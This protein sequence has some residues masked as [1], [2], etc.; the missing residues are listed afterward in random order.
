[1]RQ[2]LTRSRAVAGVFVALMTVAGAIGEWRLSLALLPVAVLSIV[3]L[4]GVRRSPRL[5]L[6][7]L[8]LRFGSA[9]G[10]RTVARRLAIVVDPPSLDERYAWDS[11]TDKGIPRVVPARIADKHKLW[12]HWAFNI[13]ILRSGL[14]ISA[15]RSG[16]VVTVRFGEGDF[17][18]YNNDGKRW[19]RQH[20]RSGE[21]YDQR[22]SLQ[23]AFV[24]GLRH[25][26]SRRD[27]WTTTVGRGFPLRWASAGCLPLVEVDGKRWV[28][29]FFRDLRP[30]GWNVANGA[31]ESVHEQADLTRVLRREFREELTVLSENPLGGAGAHPV[32]VHLR[33]LVWAGEPRSKRFE[34]PGLKL[35][36]NHDHLTILD[37]EDVQSR[38]AI[39]VVPQDTPWRIRVISA[40]GASTWLDNTIPSIDAN[41]HG[42]EAIQVVSFR[43]D[44]DNVL[45]DGEDLEKIAALVR[46]PVALFSLDAL[47]AVYRQTGGLGT[48]LPT[49]SKALPSL[50]ASFFRVDDT[51]AKLAQVRR[52]A[53][54]GVDGETHAVERQHLAPCIERHE[55]LSHGRLEP[56]LQL[57]RLGPVAWSTLEAY[58]ALELGSLGADRDVVEPHSSS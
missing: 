42:V 44:E 37:N 31:S 25:A 8:R 24:A 4:V 26:A 54:A 9:T 56:R 6:L 12:P 51:E 19:L 5:W 3:L 7:W 2:S 22:G 13:R 43:V 58:F 38:D 35:R 15:E 49:S 39:E 46:R 45:L 21:N 11:R 48:P 20:P 28:A 29:L 34:S 41:E 36:R 47:R 53:L 40:D 17:A 30:I 57:D 16:P 23:E 18:I 1:M 10:I 55:A 33:S 27:G 52:A 50:P 14:E 32:S